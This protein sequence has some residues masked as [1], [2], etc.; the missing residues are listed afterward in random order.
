MILFKNRRIKRAELSLNSGNKERAIKLALPLTK[1][2]NKEI[3][4]L[5]NKVTGLALYKQKNY[6]ESTSYLLKAV[7]IGNYRHDWYNLAMALAFSGQLNMAE[8][9]FRNIYRTTIQTGYMYTIP[10]PGM[11]FQYMKVLVK[12]QYTEAAIARANELKQM[13][14]GI[15]KSDPGKQVQRGLP[16]FTTFRKEIEALFNPE[17]LLIWEREIPQ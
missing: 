15:G 11:L 13:Y 10:V 4:Y 6:S 16:S 2:T 9:A 17:Q 7:S 5:A 1:S 3:S 14:V 8:E 12:M